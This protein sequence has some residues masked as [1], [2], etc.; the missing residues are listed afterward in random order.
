MKSYVFKHCNETYSVSLDWLATR[1]MDA[2]QAINHIDTNS[3]ILVDGKSVRELKDQFVSYKAKGGGLKRLAYLDDVMMKRFRRNWH[4]VVEYAKNSMREQFNRQVN[5]ITED[6]YCRL[7]ELG[8]SGHAFAAYTV[9]AQMMKQ[10]KPND[11]QWAVTFL[12]NA[13]NYGHVGALYRLSGYMAKKNNFEAALT[14]LVLAAD[15]GSDLAIV[16]IPDIETIQYLAKVAEDEDNLTTFLSDLAGTSRYSTARYL[17]FIVM[18]LKDDANCLSKLNDI[19][20]HPQNPPKVKDIGICYNNRSDLL[21]KFFTALKVELVNADGALKP[22]SAAE[23]IKIYKELATSKEY[24]WL[25][26]QDFM[27]IDS[28]FNL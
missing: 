4:D 20:H 22:M 12:V 6:D 17:Q 7:G 27:E 19:I 15:C 25:S 2:K 16:S 28:H 8:R 21:K 13:H 5:W 14:C 1:N 10:D 9:G 11:E 24:T 26:F 23:R 3:I 18:L